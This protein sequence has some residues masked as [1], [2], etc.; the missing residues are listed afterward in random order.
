MPQHRPELDGILPDPAYA[1]RHILT[2]TTLTKQKLS[3]FQRFKLLC[4]DW[5]G[6][7]I[8]IVPL[9]LV[10]VL[11]GLLYPV[12]LSDD[13]WDPLGEFPQQIVLNERLYPGSEDYAIPSGIAMVYLN[14]SVKVRGVK[15]NDS[16]AELD[17]IGSVS[18][19]RVVPPG[20]L[21]GRGSGSLTRAVGCSQFTFENNIPKDVIEEVKARGTP[22]LW[23]IT[24]VETPVRNGGTEKGESRVWTTSN[25]V[26]MPTNAP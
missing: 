9:L 1:I 21:F 3:V 13:K 17:V 7:I 18:W 10:L 24:G 12:V 4:S 23:R 25:F 19:Q 5:P 6:R 15:C 26:I 16:N 8:V 14:E 2:P 11:G 20:G 22:S